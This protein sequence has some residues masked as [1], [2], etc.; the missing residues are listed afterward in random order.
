MKVND[1]ETLPSFAMTAV[2]VI[3]AP[4]GALL[5]HAVCRAVANTPK[6]RR[7]VAAVGAVLAAVFMTAAAVELARDVGG[8][9]GSVRGSGAPSDD[10]QLAVTVAASLLAGWA[11]VQ[12]VPTSDDRSTA[13]V[14]VMLLHNCVEGLA[15]AVSPAPQGELPE[16]FAPLAIHNVFEGAIVI[17]ASNAAEVTWRYCIAA[18]MLTHAPQYLTFAALR[19]LPFPDTAVVI[20]Q[21]FGC[22][23]MVGTAVMLLPDGAKELGRALTFAI[24][25]PLVVV[26]IMVL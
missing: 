3:G 9:F 21:A 2:L 13:I 6:Q 22:S 4:V 26:T 1:G 19:G 12:F 8:A 16:S 11:A 23:N 20:A 14:I 17:A 15:I 5:C 24:F 7:R 18:T 10:A 25:V